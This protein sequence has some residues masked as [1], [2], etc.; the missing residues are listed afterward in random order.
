MLDGPRDSSNDYRPENSPPSN[1]FKMEKID[2]EL[3][4]AFL[5]TIL[6]P[7]SGSSGCGDITGSGNRELI[8][9]A[10]HCG[11]PKGTCAPCERPPCRTPGG[12]NSLQAREKDHKFEQTCPKSTSSIKPSVQTLI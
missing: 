4:S 1:T 6:G 12:T 9:E 3:N 2:G 7:G 8:G 10:L 11:G 5:A